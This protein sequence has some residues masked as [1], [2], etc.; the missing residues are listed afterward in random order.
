MVLDEILEHLSFGFEF[1]RTFRGRPDFGEDEID[2]VMFFQSFVIELFLFVLAS[3][4][5]DTQ[6]KK[7]LLRSAYALSIRSRFRQGA[8]RWDWLR[9]V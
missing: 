7:F 9:S 6:D 4:E 3:T 2:D 5:S 1:F 8:A